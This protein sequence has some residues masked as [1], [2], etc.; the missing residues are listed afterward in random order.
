M[1]TRGWGAFSGYGFLLGGGD[2][3]MRGLIGFT[4]LVIDE[5]PTAL[6]TLKVN[7]VNFISIWK[8]TDCRSGTSMIQIAQ[9]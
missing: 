2:K 6:Y 5:K 7:R 4:T 3:R 9:L 8:E 1:T